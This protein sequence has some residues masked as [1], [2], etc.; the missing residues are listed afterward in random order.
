MDGNLKVGT[1]NRELASM[2][3][4][5]AEADKLRSSE[6]AALYGPTWAHIW[7]IYGPIWA[8]GAQ[9]SFLRNCFLPMGT[10][11]G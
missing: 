9:F 6:K 10:D 4:A 7:S 1:L 11:I 8:P 2:A 5:K 3:K